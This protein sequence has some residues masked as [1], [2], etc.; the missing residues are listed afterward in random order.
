MATTFSNSDINNIFNQAGFAD[1]NDAVSCLKFLHT[2][3][4]GLSESGIDPTVFAKNTQQAMTVAYLRSQ[5][6][7]AIGQQ[8]AANEAAQNVINGLQA[9]IRSTQD[10][11]TPPS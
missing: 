8:Q 7:T 1:V 3:C 9:Q 5:L 10:Q 2:V 6:S 4:D 11:I